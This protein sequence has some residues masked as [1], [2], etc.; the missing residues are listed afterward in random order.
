VV[1]LRDNSG[2]WYPQSSCSGGEGTAERIKN[3]PSGP[4]L[5]KRRSMITNS[6][7]KARPGDELDNENA[8]LDRYL[9]C[10]L[11]YIP[12]DLLLKIIETKPKAKRIRRKK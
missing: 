6:I 4:P 2:A 3:P 5:I 8:T 9:I 11:E 12:S 7:I 1:A 10:P